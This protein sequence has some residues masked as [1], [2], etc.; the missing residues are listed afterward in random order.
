MSGNAS[1]KST[2]NKPNVN[3]EGEMSSNFEELNA[4]PEDAT[5]RGDEKT[6]GE[7]V[8]VAIEHP[9]APPEEPT[10]EA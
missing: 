3:A 7:T 5:P 1:H 9:Q 4:S 2:T 8:K 10:E 6:E